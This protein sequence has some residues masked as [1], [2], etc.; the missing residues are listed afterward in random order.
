MRKPCKCNHCSEVGGK[1]MKREEKKKLKAKE[2][3]ERILNEA[4]KENFSKGEA[5]FIIQP[6]AATMMKGSLS[7]V[8][9]EIFENLQEA[10]Q[11]EYKKQIDK[12]NK[13]EKVQL[14][15][16][17]K[18][19]PP[20]RVKFSDM[21]VRP[22]NYNEVQLAA[23]AMGEQRVE[24][25][26]V[27][28]AG[29]M[30]MNYMPIFTKV[31]VPVTTFEEVNRKEGATKTPYKK[32][33]RRKGYIEFTIN[34][35]VGHEYFEVKQRYTKYMKGVAKKCTCKY[36]P[37][38]Y[39]Y[40]AH[41]RD[42]G[43][44]WEFDYISFRWLLGLRGVVPTK[45]ENG[46]TTYE[47]VDLVY[48]DF[49]EVKRFVLERTQKDVKRVADKNEFD[50]YFTYD[51][52]MPKK[53]NGERATRGN[54]EKIVFHVHLSELGKHWKSYNNIQQMNIRLEYM[55]MK[56]LHMSK[57]SATSLTSRITEEI[58]LK[59]NQKVMDLIK[60]IIDPKN[61]VKD[62]GGYAYMAL[63]NFLDEITPTAMEII[64]EKSPTLDNNPAGGNV[65]QEAEDLG[66]VGE[67]SGSGQSVGN[68]SAEALPAWW[69][70]LDFIRERMAKEL[71]DIHILPLYPYSF[72]NNVLTIAAPNEYIYKEVQTKYAARLLEII[73]EHF[74][75]STE[76]KYVMDN[77]RTDELVKMY[78]EHCTKK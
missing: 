58:R 17:D 60:Y 21:D 46:K 29:D 25:P 31:S 70:V 59:F 53:A 76:A 50:C 40:A 23:I 72:E 43:G 6:H 4:Y 73:R 47:E 35:E 22:D 9:D 51:I 11:K 38:M 24:I 3:Q 44:T 65:Q 20:I 37:K 34:P 42:M 71:F 39:R 54:P 55:M 67:N 28:D 26:G 1:P 41:W 36:S 16:W 8:Q 64:P 14:S 61:G 32:N 49:G 48:P 78:E 10:F 66:N 52:V 33:E 45:D 15:L 69:K 12:L 7:L 5:D 13:K 57:Q 68:Y 56:E 18:P 63:S 30:V 75:A 74:G 2:I 27:N 19:L 62:R 77:R